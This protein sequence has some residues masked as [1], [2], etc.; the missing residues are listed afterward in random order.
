MTDFQKP[1]SSD[2]SQKIKQDI[3]GNQNQAIGQVLGGMVVYGQ[4]IYNNAP[5]KSAG[6]SQLKNAEIGPNPYQGLL[7]FQEADGERFFGRD[8]QIQEL[9]EKFH[10]L[11]KNESAIRLLS[12]Y[13]P[14]GSGKSSVARA[15]LIPAL[16][17][18]P[19]PGRDRARVVVM[20]PG[21]HP[22]EALATVLARIATNDITPVA[23][24][25]EFASELKETNSEEKYDGL[26]RIA[27][28]LPEIEIKPL[29][30][31]VDQFEEIFTLCENQSERDVFIANLLCTISE[32]SKRVSAIITLRSDFL[33]ATQK[34]PQLNQ[35]ISSQ[36]FLVTAMSI[37]S[38]RAA[39]TKPAE[40]A[41]HPLDQ[42]TVN[43]LIEQTEGREG[44]LPLL[45][46]SLT[47]IWAGLTKGKK[48]AKTLAEIGGVGGALAGE[49]QRIY[50]SLSPN[51][52]EVAR[53]VFLGLVQLGEGTQD[54]RRRTKIA[55]LTSYR[56][57][58]V[59]VKKVIDRFADREARLISLS[60]SDG[61]ETAEVS[62]EALL[63]N[64]KRLRE[65]LEHNREDIRFQ[66]R[67][68][69]TAQLWDSNGRPEGSLWRSPDLN[70]L[71]KF[72]DNAEKG[73]ITLQMTDLQKAFYHAAMD[74]QEQERHRKRQSIVQKEKQTKRILRL[75][76]FIG[77]LGL[78][79]IG[80]GGLSIWRGIEI[81]K[82]QIATLNNLSKAELASNNHLD[83]LVASVKAGEQL[84]G[85]LSFTVPSDLYRATEAQLHQAVQRIWGY[86]HLKGHPGGAYTVSFSPDGKFIAS[87]GLDKQVNLWNT[88]KQKLENDRV[89]H[90]DRV[91]DITFSPNGKI[92]ASASE[93][94]EIKIWNIDTGKKRSLGKKPKDNRVSRIAFSPDGEII[95]SVSSKSKSIK[96]WHLK[97]E[98]TE[99]KLNQYSNEVSRI[100]FSPDGEKIVSGSIDGKICLW[101]FINNK[102]SSKP[103]F[104][105]FFHSQNKKI[106]DIK[107]SHDG[108]IIAST[109][110]DET[111][112][113]WRLNNETFNNKPF[114]IFDKFGTTVNSITF[115]PCGEMIAT[116]N[117][118]NTIKLLS[119]EAQDTNMQELLTLKG[120]DSAVK[121]I[122][123]STTSSHL[124]S[125]SLDNSIRLWDLEKLLP[126]KTLR[127]HSGAVNGLDF[128]PDNQALAS[129]SDNETFISFPLN[130]KYLKLQHIDSTVNSILFHPKKQIL[131]S[132]GQDKTIKFWDLNKSKSEPRI[133]HGH[134]GPVNSLSYSPTNNLLVSASDDDTIRLWN[135]NDTEVVNQ[136]I[137]GHAGNIYGVSFSPDGKMLASASED[138]TVKLW[139]IEGKL[140]GTTLNHSS[141]V[142]AVSFSPDSQLLASAS[143]D[144]KIRIWNIKNLEDSPL[145]IFEGHEEPVLDVSFSPDGEFLTSASEDH[146]V[147]VWFHKTCRELQTFWGHKD[148]VSRVHFY[149]EPEKYLLASASWDG[150]VKIWN[151]DPDLQMNLDEAITHS[152]KWLTNYWQYNTSAGEREHRSPCQ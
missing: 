59:H 141:S 105:C 119:I 16:A 146:T 93:D 61:S 85:M 67:L 23:K 63:E 133:L 49:A 103:I 3:N 34:Y 22:L 42:A 4:V 125:A 131:F 148:S 135:L 137:K 114:N 122:S 60:V 108:K 100:A 107:F 88:S 78:T 74:A 117:E 10:N 55:S 99:S 97:G 149:S 84:Q 152:C 95:A 126:Q 14:S 64:W 145:C 31:L 139:S 92:I 87:G 116:A 53:R 69:E 94:G 57:Q 134:T 39:I 90:E 140:L 136:P 27:D 35:L 130:K 106:R 12:I 113:L 48:P 121:D 86:K 19:L 128:N 123:F 18:Q 40:S 54:T 150:T 73:N 111:V 147:K 104:P 77:F 33:G 62:H 20:V 96:F 58:S 66:R 76:G 8:A 25:R 11:H 71:E 5:V 9:W 46:F 142:N 91:T 118:D 28:A 129:A 81:Q 132:A 83:A 138:H 70:R 56:E 89:E 45:Q 7:A 124:V 29:I 143:D 72:C 38:L 98:K 26:R 24:T 36:G 21:S 13:G 32:S 102:A 52:Q 79:A 44:A 68:E 41:G 75:S 65:W 51:E 43:L 110:A 109:S 15:G 17:K 30:I 115:S 37:E 120:H 80:L 6:I 50:E 151:Y 1:F 144:R 112:K 2:S 101:E 127:N 47:R 82:S